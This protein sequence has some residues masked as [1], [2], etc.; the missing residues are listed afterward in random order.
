MGHTSLQ[1]SIKS[2]SSQTDNHDNA[3]LVYN[4]TAFGAGRGY[5]LVAKLRIDATLGSIMLSLFLMRQ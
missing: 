5:T 1:T 3:L 4:Q 2:F